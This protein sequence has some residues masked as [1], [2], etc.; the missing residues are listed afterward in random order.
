MAHD[1][2]KLSSLF[3]LSVP[4]F[5]PP[6]SPLPP[7]PSFPPCAW[8]CIAQHTVFHCLC[9]YFV[10]SDSP[11][12]NSALFITIYQSGCSCFDSCALRQLE[13]SMKKGV[14]TWRKKTVRSSQDSNLSCLNSGQMLLPTE[15]LELWH[16]SRGQMAFIHRHCSILR[17]DLSQHDQ[18]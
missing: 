12:N 11:F 15:P 5:L 4:L 8:T 13:S 7:P 14:H 1:S 9:Y 6:P 3:L 17:L 2:T 16:W 10:M 18:Y